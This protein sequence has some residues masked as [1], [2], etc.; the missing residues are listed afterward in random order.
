MCKWYSCYSQSI[1]LIVTVICKKYR[2]SQQLKQYFLFLF[3]TLKCSLLDSENLIMTNGQWSSGL[4]AVHS[5]SLWAAITIFFG[6]DINLKVKCFHKKGDYAVFHMLNKSLAG[7]IVCQFLLYIAYM[8][9]NGSLNYLTTCLRGR[10]VTMNRSCQIGTL[11]CLWY[12]IN[13]WNDC[14]L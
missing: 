1:T 14:R 2:H 13:Y 6:G 11:L 5:V 9:R 8:Q 7:F 4:A 3:V 10:Y 12:L